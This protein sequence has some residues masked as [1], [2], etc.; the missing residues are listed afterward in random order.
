MPLKCNE[1]NIE[2]LGGLSRRASFVHDSHLHHIYSCSVKTRRGTK[3]KLRV[4][5]RIGRMMEK[6]RNTG[7]FVDGLVDEPRT[8]NQRGLQEQGAR[9]KLAGL[10]GLV[11]RSAGFSD[12]AKGETKRAVALRRPQLKNPA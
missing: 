12:V 6:P 8:R 1:P 11:P 5:R 2:F 7:D 4:P 9:N 3:R 10:Y